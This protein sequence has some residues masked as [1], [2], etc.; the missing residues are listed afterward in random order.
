MLPR[1]CSQ[2]FGLLL[3]LEAFAHAAPP[4]TRVEPV[5]D[6]LHGEA[7][8]DPYRWL[9]DQQAPATREWIAAQNAHTD[10]F[11]AKFPGRQALV[12]RA[13]Q[14]MKIDSQGMPTV[15]G[16]GISSAAAPPIRICR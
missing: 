9:E 4:T 5:T 12:E 15:R 2:L 6:T 3:V 8:V 11:L 13:S 16:G 1:L 14:L 10:A 7:L